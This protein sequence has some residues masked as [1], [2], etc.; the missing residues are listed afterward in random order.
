MRKASTLLIGV[1]SLTS[2]ALSAPA[3]AGDVP[4]PAPPPPT[5]TVDATSPV[6]PGRLQVALSFLPM[7]LG[8]FT[9]APGGML[10]TQDA[11]FAP[12]AAVSVV[13]EVVPGFLVGIAPQV[14]TNVTPKE[15]TSHVALEYDVMARLVYAYRPADTIALFVEALPGYSLIKPSDGDVSKGVVL[16]FGAGV[17]VDMSSRLF[18]SLS[19][20]Y[21][22]GFQKLPAQDLN[23]D[24]R[25]TYVRV[26]LGVGMRF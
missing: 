13:Y 9:S 15:D 26:A 4:P 14:I 21:Q 23:H 25:S 20:G 3:R 8:S 16:A 1:V 24:A 7:S 17:A 11:A 12:G 18:V 19:G 6:P 2:F 22:V 5:M 10:T